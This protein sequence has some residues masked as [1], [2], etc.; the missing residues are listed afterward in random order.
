MTTAPTTLAFAKTVNAVGIACSVL[1]E[2]PALNLNK[3]KAFASMKINAIW[4]LTTATAC[5]IV[6]AVEG[7]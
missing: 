3:I 5:L 6:F 1:L 7:Q 2:R 4:L